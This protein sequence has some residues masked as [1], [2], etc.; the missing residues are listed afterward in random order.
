MKRLSFSLLI[1]TLTLE[2]QAG[3][4]A[5]KG[6]WEFALS[7]LESAKGRPSFGADNALV[8]S[9]H[10]FGRIDDVRNCINTGGETRLA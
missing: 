8:P 2:V 9:T 3:V 1:V 4:P 6:A 10:W 7:A 5:P